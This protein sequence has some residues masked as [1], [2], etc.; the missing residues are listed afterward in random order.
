MGKNNNNTMQSKANGATLVKRNFFKN[1]TSD[2]NLSRLLVL[3]VFIF[4][5]MSMLRPDRFLTMR[6]FTS[7]SFQF[8]EFGLLALG[9]MLTMLTGGIELSAVGIANL[10]GIVSA[11]LLTNVQGASGSHVILMIIASI[12]LSVII[13]ALCGMLNGFLISKVGIVPMLAT[14]GSM[15]LFTGIAIVITKGKAVHGYPEQFLFIGN[16]DIFGIP[17]PL[18]I[19]AIATLVVAILLNKTSWGFKLYMLG[20]NPTASEYSGINNKLM[21]FQTYM[22]SGILSALAGI[23][24]IARTN[25]A[26]ADYGLSYVLQAILAAVLGGVNPNGGSGKVSGLV[27]AI[28]CLQFLSSGFNMLR[29][30][31]FIKEFTWGAV[32]I[33]VMVINYLTAKK[34]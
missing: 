29:F 31:S 11:I 26:K 23:I 32:L 21:L 2:P 20:S 4:V 24:I 17:I 8:P 1:I 25:S 10:A 34:S 30:S 12:V 28:L 33:V 3:T 27:I 13:G 5:L 18:I 16:G 7:M 6:N 14:Q 22:L 15:L 19:F 9:I